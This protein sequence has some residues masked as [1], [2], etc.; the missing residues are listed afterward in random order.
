V[1]RPLLKAL[2]VRFLAG[3]A[4]SA[5][6]GWIVF[7]G[8]VF[9][10]AEISFQCITVGALTAGMLAAVR[11]SR[12]DLAVLLIVVFGMGR[13]GLAGSE[14]WLFAFSGFLLA[15]GVYLSALIFDLLAR[16]GLAFGKFLILGPL[17]GGIYVALVPL[18]QFYTLTSNEVVRALMIHLLLGL[19]IGDGAGLGVEIAELPHAAAE[20]AR[21]QEARGGARSG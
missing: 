13:F 12:H 11:L 9:H 1:S 8:T 7:R 3:L 21:Q 20:R 19:I 2:L 5:G 4:G 10:P 18:V 6:L 15:A 17:L 16:K 14:G